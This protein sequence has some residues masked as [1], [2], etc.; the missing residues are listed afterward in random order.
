MITLQCWPGLH[1]SVDL[2]RQ[3]HTEPVPLKYG[4]NSP[5]DIRRYTNIFLQ[6][7][8]TFI[9]LSGSFFGASMH[10]AVVVGFWRATVHSSFSSITLT[11]N[12]D[13]RYLNSDGNVLLISTSGP[14]WSAQKFEIGSSADHVMRVKAVSVCVCVCVCGCK[15]NRWYDDKRM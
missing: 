12:G 6:C 7:T 5:Q 1:Y 11:C 8:I 3:T 2:R 4:K 13:V 10:A 15:V 9:G 14:R